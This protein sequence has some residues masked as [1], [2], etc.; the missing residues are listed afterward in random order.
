MA[1]PL[2]STQIT[3]LQALTELEEQVVYLCQS[4]ASAQDKYNLANPNSRREA[5]LLNPD[6][7]ARSL[8]IQIILPL[9]STA[10]SLFPT[11]A[12]EA[13]F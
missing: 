7:S 3:A 4:L 2:D 10:I 12:V 9:S 6:F 13:A 5:V 1:T 11:S 8:S